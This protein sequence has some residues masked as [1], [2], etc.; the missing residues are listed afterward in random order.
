MKIL[1]RF[2][3]R[4]MFTVVTASALCAAFVSAEH[5]RCAI[6]RESIERLEPPYEY[7]VYTIFPFRLLPGR[8]QEQFQRITYLRVPRPLTVN[9]I[10]QIKNITDLRC[11]I[12]DDLSS[13]GPSLSFIAGMSSLRELGLSG[14]F[15][16]WD[17]RYISSLHQL[18]ALSLSDTD[19]SDATIARLRRL[20]SLC[21]L[22]LNRTRISNRSANYLSELP[23]LQ[24]LA[25]NGCSV[26]DSF[27]L[28]ISRMQHLREL[29]I[30]DTMIGD[31]SLAA[32]AAM[33]D[34][35]DVYAGGS[36]ITSRRAAAVQSHRARLNIKAE[37]RIS[38]DGIDLPTVR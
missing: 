35:R 32:L 13:D 24:M 20:R 16:D 37:T 21:V 6:E 27:A 25:V 31:G 18:T 23:C 33:T 17:A 12:L 4:T 5:T 26:T 10:A 3:L 30:C 2:C 36:V 7:H 8:L 22:Y 29:Q 15:T 28:S 34:L 38:G 11:L 1:P 19:V 14:I 9:D